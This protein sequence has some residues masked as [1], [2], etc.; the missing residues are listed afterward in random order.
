MVVVLCRFNAF[1]VLMILVVFV[2][3][4]FVVFLWQ[5]NTFEK[6]KRR[7]II[8]ESRHQWCT[9]KIFLYFS[10]VFCLFFCA[11]TVFLWFFGTAFL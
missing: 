3:R 6:R 8:L 9:K 11:L 1:L 2:T 7:D 5:S 4:V 10:V